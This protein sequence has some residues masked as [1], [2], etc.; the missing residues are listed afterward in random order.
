VELETP[1]RQQRNE[2]P[3][4]REL[5]HKT[6]PLSHYLMKKEFITCGLPAKSRGASCRLKPLKSPTRGS[7]RSEAERKNK[8]SRF[9]LGDK[10]GG[11]MR[12]LRSTRSSIAKGGQICIRD[13]FERVYQRVLRNGERAFR[14]TTQSDEQVG[15]GRKSRPKG[16][17]VVPGQ[18]SS[19]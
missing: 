11:T 3:V 19:I 2:V 6:S 18:S 9:I 15:M 13:P 8:G 7:T 1:T 17:Y 5:R 4:G 16:Q 14:I 12:C 10:N